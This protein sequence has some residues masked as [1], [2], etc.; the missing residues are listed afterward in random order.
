[1]HLPSRYLYT[2]LSVEG[3]GKK[4]E[5]ERERG[6]SMASVKRQRQRGERRDP[7]HRGK[8]LLAPT[9]GV[10]VHVGE[11]R[12]NVSQVHALENLFVTSPA[13][14]AARSVL[15]SQ[16]L[17]GGLQLVRDGEPLDVVAFGERGED[18]KA[19]RGVTRP[20]QQHLDQHWLPFARDVVDSFLCARNHVTTFPSSCNA[21]G[22]R[23]VHISVQEMGNCRCRL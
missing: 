8:S 10:H 11:S 9:L 18:G 19:K 22:Y 3:E 23:H 1:M 17:S 4:K 13:V 16:L 6:H 7:V 20:F 15:H 5:R 21:H 14:Q 2:S 12:L